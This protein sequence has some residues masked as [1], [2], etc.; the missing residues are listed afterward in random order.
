MPENRLAAEPSL[1]LRQHKDNPVDWWPWG[2]EALAAAKEQRK[3]IL[4]SVGYA[5]CH[6][7]HVMAH[8]S[9]EDEETAKQM[10]ADF[11]CIKVDREEHPDVDAMAMDTLRVIGQ[12][13]GWPIT[14]FLSPDGIPFFGGTYFPKEPRQG[15]PA[16]KDVLSRVASIHKEQPE[17]IQKQAAA[18][19]DALKAIIAHDGSGEMN[20]DIIEDILL[21]VGPMADRVSGGF[22]RAQKFPQ[23][24]ML[25][26]LWRNGVRIG[27]T[28]RQDF[29][30]RSLRQMSRGGIYDHLGG[31]FARYTVDSNWMVPHFEKMLYDNAL[32]L[33]TMTEVWKK[34]QDPLF[35]ARIRETVTWA[36]RE[37]ALPGGGFAA[38]LDADSEGEEGKFYLWDEAEVDA[39]LGSGEDAELF[40]ATYAVGPGGNWEGKTILNQLHPQPD[41]TPQNQASLAASRAKLFEAREK[42]PRPALDD[43][44]LAEWNGLMITGLTEAGMTFGE[45]DWGDAAKSAFQFIV[46]TMADGDRLYH[47]ATGTAPRH[48]AVAADYANMIG[49][50]LSLYE[51]TGDA[52]YLSHAQTWDSVLTTHFWDDGQ[53]SY[54]STADDGQA[55]PVR[56]RGVMDASLPSPN[57]VMLTHLTRLWLMTGDTAYQARAEKLL[58]AFG[59]EAAEHPMGFGA[60]LAGVEFYLSPIQVAILGRRDQAGTHELIEGSFAAAAPTRVV[61]QI[62]PGQNLPDHHPAFG[63]KQE[64]H[65][66]TAYVCRGAT[67]SSPVTSRKSLDH[68]LAAPSVPV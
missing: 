3:P 42:R 23:T 47:M 52:H 51:A 55:L 40:K 37:M 45:P 56:I 64:K 32:I 20:A 29:V 49:A 63:K 50:A 34:S 62:E 19:T 58:R 66:P 59:A 22:G 13:Q 65:K 57:G 21:K 4:L 24:M 46:D 38:S 5:A 31:G 68:L 26:F 53:G 28:V 12:S 60:Y 67:C 17:E 41:P 48:A 39:I 35:E 43:K 7:C 9:F 8:E 15:M 14:V 27:D 33:C 1:Y 2:P 54:Y 16:F 6:W 11:V 25:D 30:I 44:V 36:L 10:N 61:Q 18:V